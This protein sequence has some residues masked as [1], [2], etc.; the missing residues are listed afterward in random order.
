MGESK[1]ALRAAA[2]SR[3]CALSQKDFVFRSRLIQAK[4]CQYP[5]YLSAR[6]IALYASIENEVRTDEIRDHAW[7]QGK[8]VYYP[9]LRRGSAVELVRL[10]SVRQM[11]PG[12]FDILEPSGDE[13]WSGE[14]GEDLFILV[15]G[16]AFDMN[17]NRLGRGQGWYDRLLK[18]LGEGATAAGLAYDFQVVDQVPVEPWDET[19][20]YI[21]T[22]TRLIDCRETLRKTLSVP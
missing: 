1:S 9:K 10:E 17:G 12:R 4:V 6:S 14:C 16:L 18:K 11:T 8:R 20:A 13:Q 2:S 15:P 7:R 19:V 22:E 3:R 5:E 21:F